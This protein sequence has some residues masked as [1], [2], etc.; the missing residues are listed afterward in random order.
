MNKILVTG[1]GFDLN[2]GL[3]TSYQNFLNSES[4][5]KISGT[6]PGSPAILSRY[7]RNVQSE[8]NWV[9]IEDELKNFVFGLMDISKGVTDSPYYKKAPNLFKDLS[10][11]PEYITHYIGHTQ[12]N[13]NHIKRTLTD[14]LNSLFPN[15]F[16]LPNQASAAIL[17]A[18]GALTKQ[19]ANLPHR[20]FDKVYTFN[21]TPTAQRLLS[22]IPVTYLH[23]SLQDNNIVF[24]VE[25]TAK[26]PDGFEYLYKSSSPAYS[27][28]SQGLAAQMNDCNEIHFFGLSFGYTDDSHF[29]P[30]FKQ[31]LNVKHTVKIFFYVYGG[32][33]SYYGL[34]KRLRELTEY[35]FDLFKQK[36]QPKFISLNDKKEIDDAWLKNN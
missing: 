26:L 22:N 33:D 9:D 31:L 1:N 25:D 15:V 2:L 19:L 16:S 23:G 14:Y 29:K 35:Q 7:L 21:Y 4:F 20:D 12:D 32:A 17:L 34:F 6:D 28:D 30:L 24:G 3:K 5:R 8:K 27:K 13:Y 18:N 10:K 36:H 11:N